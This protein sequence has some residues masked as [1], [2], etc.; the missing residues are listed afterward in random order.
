[1][2]TLMQ[3]AFLVNAVAMTLHIITG[4]TEASHNSLVVCLLIWCVMNTDKEAAE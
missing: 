3:I 2:R 1:M 4:D